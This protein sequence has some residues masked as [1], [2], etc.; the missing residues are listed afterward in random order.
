M[1]KKPYYNKGIEVLDF[2]NSWNMNF[3]LGN[4]I[5]YVCRA[6]LKNPETEL[7]DLVKAKNYLDRQI[8]YIKIKERNK[9][10]ENNE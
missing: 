4:V 9:E 2:I 5:K 6:G 7:E 1:D 10:I 3:A 8:N